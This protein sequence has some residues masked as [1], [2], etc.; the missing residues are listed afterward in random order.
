MKHKFVRII[1]VGLAGFIALTAI[2]GG[3]A[4]LMGLDS[5]PLEWLEGTPFRSYTIPALLLAGVVGGSAL[6]AA[7]LVWRGGRAGVVAAVAAGLIMAGY[8]VVEVLIL[9]QVPP[10]PTMIEILY[11]VLGLTIFVL[12][13]YLW[14]RERPFAAG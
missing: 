5:F 11:F 3:V 10:G 7:V 6:A 4:M 2:G 13:V 12:G 1:I 9:K 14:G 8:I